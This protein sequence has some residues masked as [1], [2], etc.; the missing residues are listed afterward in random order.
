MQIELPDSLSAGL[1][2]RDIMT[3]LAVGMYAA[4]RVSLG[5]AAQLASL[6]QGE[7]QQE[8]GRRLIPLQYDLEDLA[9][10][11]KAAAEI[12]GR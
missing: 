5:Q 1:E 8:L 3:D 6:S 10:D 12:S 4:K 9:Q 7:F 2:K 11:L